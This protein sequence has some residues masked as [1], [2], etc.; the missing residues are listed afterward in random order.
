METEDRST[1]ITADDDQKKLVERIVSVDRIAFNVSQSV[2]VTTEDKIRL[3][4]DSYL[5]GAQ[6]R[7]E[8]IAPF[9][10][11]VAIITT[12]V[13]A[14]FND[15]LFSAAT[16]KAVFV[17]V[18]IASFGWLISSLLYLRKKETV[19]DLINDLKATNGAEGEN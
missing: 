2:V 9:G 13:T 18:G 5:K 3:A 14:T 10:I 6:K 11:L 19:D 7:T 16:W 8:W 12:L 4:L 1:K 15:W 17:L